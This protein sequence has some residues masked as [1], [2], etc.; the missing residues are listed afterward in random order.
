MIGT[1]NYVFVIPKLTTGIYY[2]VHTFKTHAYF[3]NNN[4]PDGCAKLLSEY[5]SIEE[6]EQGFIH[7]LENDPTYVQSLAEKSTVKLSK[8]FRT[9]TFTVAESRFNHVSVVIKGKENGELIRSF[10]QHYLKK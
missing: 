2:L 7:L 9:F 8:L 3:S 5:K 10:Y 1:K 4:V 6:L